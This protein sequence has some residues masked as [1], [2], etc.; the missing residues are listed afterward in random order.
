MNYVSRRKY[1]RP[2]GGQELEN[3]PTGW[4]YRSYD[5]SRT[6]ADS[7]WLCEGFGVSMSAVAVG[8]DKP[9]PYNEH[10][11]FANKVFCI[12]K[13]RYCIYRRYP[14]TGVF[15]GIPYFLSKI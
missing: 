9:V 14:G 11:N 3:S 10:G 2:E 5:Y 13:I 15:Q 6:I 8:L 4:V 1:Q 12:A 7:W